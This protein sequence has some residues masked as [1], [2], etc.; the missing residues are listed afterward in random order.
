MLGREDKPGIETEVAM[1]AHGIP[2]DWPEAVLTEARTF[3]SKVPAKA[4]EGREDLRSLPLVTIDGED[5]KDF[6]DAVYCEPRGDGWRL[7]VAIADVSHYVEQI[8]RSIARP[9]RA[10]HPCI[11]P[12]ASCRCC[13]RSCR[14]GCAR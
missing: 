1:L 11:S 9:A 7:I 12:T 13:P 8:P 3:A 2:H 14:T 4:K 6:D 5:A 10:A